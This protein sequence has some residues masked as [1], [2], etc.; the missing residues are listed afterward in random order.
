MKRIP[1]LDIPLLK[2]LYRPDFDPSKLILNQAVGS[3]PPHT[4]EEIEKK[5]AEVEA[6]LFSGDAPKPL[7]KDEAA[8]VEQQVDALRSGIAA[9]RRRIANVSARI[10]S[11]G[12]PA[13]QAEIGFQVD[14]KRKGAL[15]RAVKKV[16]GL[17]PETLT[18]SMYKAALAAKKQLEEAEAS[19]Y[20]KGEWEN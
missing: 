15:R 18:Y 8:A 9:T 13:G 6:Q 5:V 2:D 7:T 17:K 3:T 12:A 11:Q 4:Q 14:L 19:A 16:F 20:S 10:D 1:D